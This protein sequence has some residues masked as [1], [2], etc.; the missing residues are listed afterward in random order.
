MVPGAGV[1]NAASGLP[2]AYARSSSVL[3]IAGQIPQGQIG[4]NLGA[5]HEV[6]GQSGVV[7][8]LSR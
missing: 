8:E 3:L 2:T 6:F 5:I 7:E 1:Y 4:K